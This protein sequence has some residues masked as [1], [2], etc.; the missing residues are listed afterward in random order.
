MPHIIIEYSANLAEVAD[1]QELVDVVHEAALADGLPA[2]D[3]LRTRAA[4]R[5]HFRIADGRPEFAFV[6]VV[7]RIGPGRTS[8]DKQRFLGALIE[9]VDAQL[10]PIADRCRV[11]LSAEVQEIDP[12]LRINR[13]HVRTAM[14]EGN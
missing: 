5:D 12:D 2:L 11:A 9:A 6:S 8:D 1:I 10:A 4:V 13:N 7:A 14:T 3:A